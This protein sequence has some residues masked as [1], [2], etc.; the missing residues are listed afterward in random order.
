MKEHYE[1]FDMHLY[2]LETDKQICR[3]FAKNGKTF[4]NRRKRKHRSQ[5]E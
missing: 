3:N 4:N 2:V 1:S 5:Q